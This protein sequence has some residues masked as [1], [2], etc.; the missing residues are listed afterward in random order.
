MQRSLSE[1]LDMYIL[2]PT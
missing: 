2:S 1:D